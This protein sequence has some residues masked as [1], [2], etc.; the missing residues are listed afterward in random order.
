[1]VLDN[2]YEKWI[3]AIHND[4]FEFLK[5]NSGQREIHLKLKDSEF[6]VDFKD[7]KYLF[8]YFIENTPFNFKIYLSFLKKMDILLFSITNY[9]CYL[10][11]FF[12]EEVILPNYFYKEENSGSIWI[13]KSTLN[14]TIQ[15]KE[16]L[17]LFMFCIL[18]I[19]RFF[20]QNYEEKKYLNY[21]EQLDQKLYQ[22]L[23]S[24]SNAEL[25]I[26]VTKT[27]NKYFNAIS[28]NLLAS[29]EISVFKYNVESY[30]AV[31][32][33]INQ[34]FRN[35]FPKNHS[36]NFEV[37]NILRQEILGIPHL[38]DCGANRL[39][40]SAAGFHELHED[41]LTYINIIG[42][43]HMYKLDNIALNA[44]GF[45]VFALVLDDLKYMDIFEKF[46]EGINPYYSALQNYIPRVLLDRHG[47]T[48][49]SVRAYL[50]MCEW[51]LNNENCGYE[52]R[53]FS[54]YFNNVASIN[55]LIEEINKYNETEH[56]ITSKD[57]VYCFIAPYA[58]HEDSEY[59][60]FAIE[61]FKTRK[62]VALYRELS[63][64]L[65]KIE[66]TI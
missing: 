28:N 36:L 24:N 22:E 6:K 19:G 10:P 26:E 16:K 9:R 64:I 40:N 65:S 13:K 35:G 41:I 45:A 11:E 33:Y 21:V 34:L 3:N 15:D 23:I 61:Y 2:K 48:N 63:L 52:L 8:K 20:D 50:Q 46:L 32:D 44:Q 4:N 5:G 55:I 1:M 51:L 27:S 39:F 53:D 37:K 38:I 49:E 14:L 56:K 54:A 30:K 31:L 57:I 42:D 43:Y 7:L 58:Y 29:I 18:T 47:V 60:Q 62:G 17:K 66:L 25:G 12:A 59:D